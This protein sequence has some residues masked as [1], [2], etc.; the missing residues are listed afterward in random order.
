[1]RTAAGRQGQ[2][3]TVRGTAALFRRR[4]RPGEPRS[5]CVVKGPSGAEAREGVACRECAKRALSGAPASCHRP[6]MCR[7][8]GITR[9]LA[10]MPRRG[11]RPGDALQQRVPSIAGVGWPVR[12][13]PGI[14]MPA[15][16]SQAA[17][18]RR[19]RAPSTRGAAL[20]CPH[21]VKTS[22]AAGR[23]APAA[24][25]HHRGGCA[26]RSGAGS[27]SC[28]GHCRPAAGQAPRAV[29]GQRRHPCLAARGPSRSFLE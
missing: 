16:G 23:A 21:G 14:K 4:H 1:M 17:D 15:V 3:R 12:Q 20:R 8:S 10:A 11:A 2:H 29:P 25:R 13:L 9:A 18:A 27:G 7:A 26:G 22:D 28:R 5:R 19:H 24:P 6:G